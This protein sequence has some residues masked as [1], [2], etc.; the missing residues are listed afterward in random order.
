MSALG[1]NEL[2]DFI[3]SGPTCM[4]QQAPAPALA[5]T[6]V[7]L[8]TYVSSDEGS[9]TKIEGPSNVRTAMSDDRITTLLQ[10]YTSD[11]GG[12]FTSTVRASKAK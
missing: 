1:T 10:S 3:R 7:A 11:R 12:A 6:P 5:P 8:N 4:Q 9:C 2:F